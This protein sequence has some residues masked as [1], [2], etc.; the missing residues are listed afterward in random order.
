MVR[1]TPPVRLPGVEEPLPP[2]EVV[3]WQGRPDLIA[4]ALR[5]LHL[6]ALVAYWALVTLGL[7]A[8]G[9]VDGRSVLA[10]LAWM[11]AVALVG[12]GLILLWAVAIRSTTTYA[13][14]SRRVVLRIGVALP[15]VLN[16]PLDRIASV[17]LRSWGGGEG[18]VVLTPAGGD[19]FGWL[20][21]WPHARP[22]RLRDPLPALR[23]IPRAGEVGRILA[24]AVAG[25]HAGGEGP[26][27]VAGAERADAEADVEEEVA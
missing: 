5:V 22:W 25:A 26:D 24:G 21:L 15:V 14:T 6:R 1:D 12:S 3:L 23:A 18:D 20:L 27:A 4:V 11:A 9:A 19:R 10:D 8:F 7:V 17:D 16:L 2:G 13:V